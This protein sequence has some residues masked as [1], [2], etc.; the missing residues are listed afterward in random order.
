MARAVVVDRHGGE[1]FFE[2]V[3]LARLA[4]VE[5][6]MGAFAKAYEHGERASALLVGPDPA[7]SVLGAA[8]AGAAA[9]ALG[10]IERAR[11]LLDGAAR[12]AAS[13]GARWAEA[14]VEL[15]RAHLDLA[16]GGEA[17][18]RSAQDRLRRIGAQGGLNYEEVRSARRALERALGEKPAASRSVADEA[19]VVSRGGLWFRPPAGKRVSLRRR[20]TLGRVLVRLAHARETSPGEPVSV[21][22]LLASGWPEEHVTP[23]AGAMRVWNALSTLRKLGLAE[24]ITTIRRGYFLDPTVP[25]EWADGEA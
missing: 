8:T 18:R 22:D 24:E 19:L 10:R 4:S 13:V 11:E 17:G 21:E 3:H 6:E 1:R 9:A 12:L 7:S 2:G 23:R 20:E 14:I 15:D 16:V 25:F 5:L